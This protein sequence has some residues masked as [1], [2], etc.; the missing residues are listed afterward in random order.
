MQLCLWSWTSRY[1]AACWEQVSMYQPSWSLKRLQPD[2]AAD[3]AVPKLHCYWWNNFLKN[4]WYLFEHFPRGHHSTECCSRGTNDSCKWLFSRFFS[5]S[6][7]HD[8]FIALFYFNSVPTV[9][10]NPFFHQW[11]KELTLL[12]SHLDRVKC[13]GYKAAHLRRRNWNLGKQLRCFMQMRKLN[14]LL[15]KIPHASFS[16]VSTCQNIYKISLPCRT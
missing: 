1:L 9:N 4:Q 8:L 16:L 10:L 15:L 11:Y 13:R 2:I 12:Q 6:S 14:W 7:S 5:W 3:Q